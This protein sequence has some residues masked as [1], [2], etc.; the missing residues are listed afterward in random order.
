MLREL[1]AIEP[2]K[3]ILREYTEQRL[4]EDC[5]RVRCLYGA[6]KHGTEFVFF[7][8]KD[9]F[10]QNVFDEEYQLFVKKQ[11]EEQDSFF[12]GLGNMWVGEITEKGNNVKLFEIG[13]KVS[14]YG[15]LRC[16]HTAKE[17]ELLRM[18]S[19]MTWKEAVCYDPSQYA[20]AGVRDGNIRL[21]DTVAV[22]GLGAIGLLAAQ[23]SKLSGALKVIVIDPIEARRNVAIKNGA[24]FAIDPINCDVGLEIKKLTNK[25]GADVIVETSGS[26]LAMQQAIRGLAYCG[27]LAVVGWYKE[28]KGNLNFGLEAHFN[29]PNIIFSRACSEPNRDYPRWTFDRNNATCWEML[30]KGMLSCEDIVDPV[31]DFE[32]VAEAY[33]DIEQN[34]EKSVKLGVQF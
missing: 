25:K 24:D 30:S 11:Q 6:P 23:M 29:Q 31:V 32:N 9:P 28:C 5:V 13:D 20:L 12:I 2:S 14:G 33:L 8:G 7:N 18:N 22:F 21:G 16:T 1:V 34:P 27:N 26:Y 15:I 4:G 10:Q 3:P 17:S 19:R